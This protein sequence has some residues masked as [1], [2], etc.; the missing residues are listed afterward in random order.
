[1]LKENGLLDLKS[2]NLLEIGCGTGTVLDEYYQ[3]GIN[4]TA[5]FGI[6]LLYDSLIDAQKKLLSANIY[7]AD[8]QEL[9]FRQESFTLVLQ[10]TAFS[11]VLDPIIKKKMATEMLR[12]LKPRGKI[13]WYDFWWNPTNRQ[14]RGIKLKEI[15]K[16][17]PNCAYAF[18]K[19]T[20]AP[21]IARRFVPISL[22]IARFLESLKIFNSH[23]LVVITKKD[24]KFPG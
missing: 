3:K 5:L 8:G 14:T 21:P 10:Y 15:R 22:G 16:L 1:M 18:K 17:F 7:N 9:P 19:I 13:I 2:M 23:Y 24:R 4:P 6:D 12:V 11:S 20:L